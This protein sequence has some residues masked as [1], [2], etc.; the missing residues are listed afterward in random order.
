MLKT[1]TSKL[2]VFA[3]ATAAALSFSAPA[4]ATDCRWQVKFKS[5]KVLDTGG[6]RRVE[7]K[8]CVSVTGDTVCSPKNLYTKLKKM[9]TKTVGEEIKKLT[10]RNDSQTFT[11][12]IN[13]Q[14]KGWGG[15]GILADKKITLNCTRSG[16]NGQDRTVNWDLTHNSGWKYRVTLALKRQ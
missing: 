14:E 15:S 5:Y 1:S 2:S 3:M 10:V 12:K 7:A 16:T 8:V 9:E 13:A 11:V 6:E 4:E